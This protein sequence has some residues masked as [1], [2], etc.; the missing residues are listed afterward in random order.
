VGGNPELAERPYG[1][2]GLREFYGV[3]VEFVAIGDSAGPLTKQA[4]LDGTVTMGDL[5]SADPDIASSGFVTLDDPE[6]MFLAQ[7]VV[8]LVSA[9]IADEVAELIN[10][11]S[12]LLTT[13]EL[14]GL[15]L[16]STAEEL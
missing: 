5:Y 4:I 14:V 6:G 12:T 10:A 1:P 15:N 3:E 16:R 13:D 7:N 9:E 2:D 8:P 11:V